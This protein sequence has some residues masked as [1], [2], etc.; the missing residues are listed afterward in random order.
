[1]LCRIPDNTRRVVTLAISEISIL[2]SVQILL[3]AA[4][5]ALPD[6]YIGPLRPGYVGGSILFQLSIQLVNVL[7]HILF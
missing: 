3:Y 5:G 7:S 6:Y 1:M 2:A 4:K